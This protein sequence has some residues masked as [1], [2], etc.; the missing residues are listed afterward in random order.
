MS[1]KN[2][3]LIG[4][5]VGVILVVLSILY[6][7]FSEG[8]PVSAW[9]GVMGIFGL[10]LYVVGAALF[11]IG[12]EIETGPFWKTW[13]EQNSGKRKRGKKMEI[14]VCGEKNFEVFLRYVGGNVHPKSIRIPCVATGGLDPRLNLP[15]V[16]DQ[17]R[18]YI[19]DQNPGL[20]FELVYGGMGHVLTEGA[21]RESILFIGK[22]GVTKGPPHENQPAHDL[23]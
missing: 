2:I 15:V 11:M 19:T 8:Q 18:S 16:L 10:L 7:L 5:V 23:P 17:L 21:K 13:E 6:L 12:T 22:D 1:V 14:G 20:K 9:I 4:A 3:G